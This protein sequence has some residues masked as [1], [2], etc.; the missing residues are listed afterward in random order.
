MIQLVAGLKGDDMVM[1]QKGERLTPEQIGLL[2][3][4]IDQGADWPD[5]A[6]SR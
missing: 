1:P 5:S 4:W 2:R 3:A 6:P